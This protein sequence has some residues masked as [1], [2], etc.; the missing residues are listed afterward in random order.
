M[1]TL[2]GKGPIDTPTGGEIIS[3][4]GIFVR[5]FK[6]FLQ[7]NCIARTRLNAFYHYTYDDGLAYYVVK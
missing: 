6:F 5:H 1:I 3:V 7:R 2:G 4:C